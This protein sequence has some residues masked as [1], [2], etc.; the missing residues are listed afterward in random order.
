MEPR[1]R[2]SACIVRTAPLGWSH[3]PLSLSASLSVSAE[4][5][6]SGFE[7]PVSSCP[8]MTAATACFW[9]RLAVQEVGVC[10]Y[11]YSL[12]MSE[13]TGKVCFDDYFWT[14]ELGIV[15]GMTGGI[16]DLVFKSKH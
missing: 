12:I 10:L 6:L 3:L 11:S 15:A 4:K 13:W 9:K 7:R 5:P 1:V 8:E 2:K 14:G 16:V